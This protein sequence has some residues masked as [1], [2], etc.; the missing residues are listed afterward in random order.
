M[1]L[2]VRVLQLLISYWYMYILW[3]LAHTMIEAEHVHDLPSAGWG[4]RKANGIIQS[5]KTWEPGEPMIEVLVQFQRPDISEQKKAD[6]PAQEERLNFP[7]LYLFVLFRPSM[8]WK[9]PTHTGGGVVFFTQSTCSNANL[10]WKQTHKDTQKE[11]F[12][13]YMASLCPVKLT[14]KINP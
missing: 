2:L 14:Q 3:K 7:F 5:P 8:D 12:I 10:F 4:I 1:S 13:G 11:C 9:M 6:T